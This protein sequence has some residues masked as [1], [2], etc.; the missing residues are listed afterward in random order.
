M[1]LAF[2]VGNTN[3]V[4]GCF[5]GDTL[6]EVIRLKTDADRTVDEYSALIFPLL[7]R[8]FGAPPEIK[9]AIISS[10]VPSVI[11]DI[12]RLLDRE[13]NL[14]AIVV[15]AGIKTGISIRVKE[16][17]AVGA[18]RIVNSFA[19][20]Q[21]YGYPS[22][23]IDFGTATSFDVVNSAGDYEGGIIAPGVQISLDALVRRTAKLPRIKLEWPQAVIGRNTEEAMQSGVVIGY[24]CLIEGL[25]A[26]LTQELGQ[27]KAVVATGGLGRLFAEKIPAI[28]AYEPDLTLR[29]LSLIYNLNR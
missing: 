18:D 11:G 22:I 14:K 3:T 1:L 6:V 25:L 29:G 16:P 13:L 10:V 21:I 24:Q 26:K 19:I 9:D 2:D 20:K 7:E 12:Q 5:K 23:V 28:T 8:R 17:A 4:I 27:P 15:G